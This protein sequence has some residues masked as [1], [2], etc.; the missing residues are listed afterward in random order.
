M[1]DGP[2]LCANLDRIR[3]R[4]AEAAK[5][6]GRSAADI[7]LIAV[8]KYVDIDVTRQLI[9]AGCRQL[10]EARPQELWHKAQALFDEALE[11]HLIGHLQRNKIARTL[12]LARLIHSGDSLRLIEAIDAEADRAGLDPVPLLLEVNVSGDASKHGFQP[13][14][15]E[16]LGVQL[17]GLDHISVRGM[18]CMA[19]REGDLDSARRDFALLRHLRD[20]LRSVWP[21]NLGLHELSMGMSGDFEVAIE[22]GATMVRVGSLL[23]ERLGE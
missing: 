21:E 13:D 22:E 7:K 10:G 12:P 17:A 4:M 8:T 23:F 6:S 9:A 2:Q 5:R 14:E 18:M 16:P 1:N 15:L 19:G 11:W 3:G 20:Q